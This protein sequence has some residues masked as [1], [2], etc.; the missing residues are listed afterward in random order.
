MN[1]FG[2]DCGSS[3]V[4]FRL[5]AVDPG[6]PAAAARLLAGGALK[7][8]YEGYGHPDGH[9]FAEAITGTA[10]QGGG[11]GVGYENRNVSRPREVPRAVGADVL[12]KR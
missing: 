6:A 11:A 8:V 4:K 5:L 9:L 2:L 12:R 3:S 10:M 1:V 7:T